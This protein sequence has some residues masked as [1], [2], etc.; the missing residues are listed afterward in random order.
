MLFS[1]K[2][3]PS[4][5]YIIVLGLSGRSARYSLLSGVSYHYY[6]FPLL[7]YFKRCAHVSKCLDRVLESLV[8]LCYY[9][10]VQIECSTLIAGHN[11]SSEL[12]CLSLAS[13]IPQILMTWGRCYCSQ[14]AP[15]CQSS[16]QQHIKQWEM[17]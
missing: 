2:Q 17:C 8:L 5:R 13:V 10:S 11:L 6:V 14:D 7:I 4:S 15:T 16:I 1:A 12:F 3:E 9:L